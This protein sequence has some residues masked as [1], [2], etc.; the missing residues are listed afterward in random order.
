MSVTT[1]LTRLLGIERTVMLAAMD[2]L[3]DARLTGAI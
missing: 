3:A 2:K 1:R